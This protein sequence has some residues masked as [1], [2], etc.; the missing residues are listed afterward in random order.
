MHLREFN[1]KISHPDPHHSS[2]VFVHLNTKCVRPLFISAFPLNVLSRFPKTYPEKACPIFTLQQPMKGLS[3]DRVTKLTHT[4]NMES[5]KKR[6]A[7][8]VLE[9]SLFIP[10][11]KA[12]I[13]LVR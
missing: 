9:V 1:I 12:L 4:I 3:S 11:S 6:G 2:N 8:M 10:H 7:E 13:L 5:Q